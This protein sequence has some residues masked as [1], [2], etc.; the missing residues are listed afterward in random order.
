MGKFLRLQNGRM[1]MQDEAAAGSVY[2]ESLLLVSGSP[3]AGEITGPITAGTPITLPSSKTY[4]SSELKLFLNGMSL[5]YLVDFNYVGTVPRT[6]ISLTFDAVVG[7]RIR[8]RI[9]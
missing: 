4:D 8:F 3:G 6:Q 1:T 9:N 5:E 7:D 2:D